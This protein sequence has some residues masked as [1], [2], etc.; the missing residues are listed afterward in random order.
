MTDEDDT[1]K[2]TTAE[3]IRYVAKHF[4]VPSMYA[5]AKSLSS[6]DLVV[7]TIQV[8]N[9][10]NGTRMSRKVAER[11]NEVYSII[12]TDQIGDSNWAELNKE[13]L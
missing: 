4:N 3:A 9:Y 12:I 1:T 13:Q 8:K 2:L 5:L 10:L 6:D 11:F 7:Q